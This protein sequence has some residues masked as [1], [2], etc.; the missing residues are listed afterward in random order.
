MGEI[1]NYIEVRKKLIAMGHKF[2]TNSDTEV[3]I[4]ALK[5]W[6]EKAVDFLEGMWAFAWYDNNSKKL[7]LSRD[8]FGE[9]PLYYFLKEK[10]LFFS[11]EIKSLSALSSKRFMII[12]EK[13]EEF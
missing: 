11:S 3:L 1:Y 2:K 10:N 12:F 7:I 5:Q 8:R 9:K 4:H 13:I 6:K